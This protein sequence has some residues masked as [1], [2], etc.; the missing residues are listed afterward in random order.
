MFGNPLPSQSQVMD[1]HSLFATSNAFQ[2]KK[3]YNDNDFRIKQNQNY[4]TLDGDLTLYEGSPSP[5]RHAGANIL[6]TEN[7]YNALGGNT[8]KRY[9][10]LPS[11][12]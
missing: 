2:M 11:L 3:K 7:S 1:D 8:A 5:L 4:R 12:N 9:G 10:K 6:R